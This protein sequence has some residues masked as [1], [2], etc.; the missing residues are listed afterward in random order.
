MCICQFF[1]LLL[2]GSL[3]NSFM[4]RRF[5]LDR[6]RSGRS[7]LLITCLFSLA[8]PRLPPA[9]TVFYKRNTPPSWDLL[10]WHD[11]ER[12][13]N[14]NETCFLKKNKKSLSCHEDV[15]V[16]PKDPTD[17]SFE[18]D[19]PFH[20][21]GVTMGEKRWWHGRVTNGPERCWDRCEWRSWNIVQVSVLG[22]VAVAR[23]RPQEKTPPR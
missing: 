10:A 21:M 13:G 8:L 2:L 20:L 18:N 5:P 9:R 16:T 1:Q 19:I 15:I 11:I 12:N 23:T 7:E 4:R 17:N 6:V 3:W 22:P 14:S